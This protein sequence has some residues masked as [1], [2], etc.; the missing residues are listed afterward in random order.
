M[1]GSADAG[2]IVVSAALAALL[3]VDAAGD[4]KGAGRLLRWRRARVEPSGPT[5]R[6]SMDAATY[7]RS[8]PVELRSFLSVARS[9]AEHRI[10]TVGFV[11]FKGIAD[12]WAESGGS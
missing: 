2:E 10:A 7:E 5:A 9:E 6:R 12:V 3:P 11:K 8:V 1:E 4:R